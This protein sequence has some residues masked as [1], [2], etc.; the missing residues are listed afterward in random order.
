MIAPRRTGSTRTGGISTREHRGWEV[1]SLTSSHLH[2]D[3]LPQKGGDILAVRTVDGGV[4]V[5]WKSPWGLRARGEATVSPDSVVNFLSHYPGGWQTI[6][7]NGGDATE[8]DGVE[9]PFHGE[10]CIAAWD[11]DEVSE[12]ADGIEVVLKTTLHLTPFEITKHMRLDGPSLHVAET[13]HNLSPVSQEV[14]WS[15]HPAFGAPLVS[16]ATRVEAAA[17]WF[18]ADDARDV[19]AGDLEPG[20]KSE[21]PFAKTR[22][23]DQADLRM[24]P[25]EDGSSDRFGYL[26]GFKEGR[27]SINNPKLGLRAVL[28]WDVETFPFAWY[29]LEAHAT[30]GYP[31]YGRAYVFA[32]EPASSYPGQGIGSVRSKTQTLLEIPPGGE[33]SVWVSLEVGE[34]GR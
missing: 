26:G 29:W 19:P 17:D 33:R 20:A 34:T 2:V 30:T 23:G 27:A 18:K 21:W 6:F 13:V 3:V 4:D 9:L 31:W 5:L 25:S 32:I 7:P 1:V 22:R 24:M 28:T 10:A 12:G 8:V 16:G 11:W 15:H 14:M